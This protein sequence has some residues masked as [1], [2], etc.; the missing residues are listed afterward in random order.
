MPRVSIV[1]PASLTAAFG[2][3]RVSSRIMRAREATATIPI[4]M[5]VSGDPVGAGHIVS[6]SRPGG[7]VTGLSNVSPELAGKRLEL[8]KEV[9]PRLTRVAVLGQPDHPDWQ[10]VAVAATALG[11]RIQ[12]LKVGRRAEFEDAFQLAARERASG[13]MVLPSPLTNRYRGTLVA[14]AESG[15]LP[16]VYPLREYAEVGGLMAYG[17]N[18]PEMY[19][20]AAT[21]VDKILRGAKAS[22][23]PVEQPTKFELAINLKTAKALGLTIPPSLLLRVDQV[24]E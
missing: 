20:R 22:D 24:I 7:N 17:P 6:L 2:V 9:A 3:E 14:L 21:Y 4:I 19:R 8:L 18:I 13:L 12:A 1:A 5:T 11:V 23:L 16:T 15:R 10:Q